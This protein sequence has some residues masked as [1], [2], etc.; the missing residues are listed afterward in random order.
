MKKLLIYS[1][2]ILTALSVIVACRK[3]DNPKLPSGLTSVP[4][5]QFTKD[6][7]ADAIIAAQVPDAFAGK[8]TVSLYFS[9]DVAPKSVDIMIIKNGVHASAKLLLA[10]VTSFPTTVTI[11]GAQLKTLFGT[12]SVLGD[13][14][15]IGGT[16]TAADGTV[17]PAFSTYE[18]AASYGSGLLSQG[19][20]GAAN[21]KYKPAAP[22]V[23]YSAVCK[24]TMTDYGAIGAIIPFTV[25]KDGWGDYNPGDLVPVTIVDA[26]HFSFYY[27]TDPGPSKMPVVVTVNPTTNS[28]SAATGPIGT[29]VLQGLSIAKYGTWGVVNVPDATNAVVS[30]CILQFGVNVNFTATGTGSTYTGG[31][32]VLKK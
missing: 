29:Y 31:A 5:L 16:I 15:D 10:N 25:V 32:I 26:T 2:A 20:T 22:T 12:S 1:F 11:T 21:T 17:I 8:F 27:A 3:S 19:T 14:Y 23:N 13:S 30:P 9:T 4:L 7:T 24:F 18:G 6:A 28:T